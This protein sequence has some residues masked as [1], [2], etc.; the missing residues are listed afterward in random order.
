MRY[1]RQVIFE[2]I[3]EVK[4]KLLEES[5]IA[6]VGVGALGT[7]VS[8][9]LT[10]A[11]VKKLILVDRDV[12][13]L[14][15]LQRQSLFDENDIN[16]LKAIAAKEKLNK[17]NS[18][19]K[20]YAYAIDLDHENI[21]VIKSDLIIDCTDNFET[22][23]LINDFCLREKIPW[24]YSSVIGSY[25][26][27]LNIIPKKTPCFRCIFKEPTKLL[28]TCDTEG[29]INTIPHAIAGMLVTEAI[30][31]LTKH[32]Y[33]RELVYYDIWKNKINKTK[34]KK[35]SGCPACNKNYEYLDGKERDI[36]KLCGTNS[37][38]IKNKFDMEELN[39]KFSRLG[40]VNLTEHCLFFNEF[41]IFKDR[42]LIKAGSKEE[43]KNLY[44]KY[45][46]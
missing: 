16:N 8:E 33:N 24:I 3:G 36:I 26:M 25:G 46:G 10:R 27:T 12:I 23:F 21:G 18:C 39:K 22:R 44:D 4:Q 37:Y 20:I 31:I 45:L 15:N 13:E 19:I 32:P 7:I 6:V 34:V 38:Q 40:K 1:I 29:I 9:L 35:L 17:I 43:A 2:K 41:V 14:S 28:G 5:T 11:G 30:K 42:V